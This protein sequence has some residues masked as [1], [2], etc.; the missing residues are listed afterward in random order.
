VETGFIDDKILGVELGAGNNYVSIVNTHYPDTLK[1]RTREIN[2][3]VNFIN[4]RLY[5][6]NR[7]ICKDNSKTQRANIRHR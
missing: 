3:I 7:M 6:Y 2:E 4:M 5:N 1:F